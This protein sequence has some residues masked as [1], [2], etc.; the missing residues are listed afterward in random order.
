MGAKHPDTFPRGALLGA[1]VLVGLALA[2]TGAARLTGIGIA[3]T[4]EATSTAT[5]DLRFEDR[6]D[7]AVI[8]YDAANGR[9]VDILEPGTNGFVRGV[10]RAL[11]RERK[12]QDIGPA[13][14]F[15]L[16]RWGDGRLSIEDVATQERIELV[17]FGPTNAA[18]FARLL[19][20]RSA[21][22]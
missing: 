19:Y 17:S 21:S 8:V 11:V 10:L 18:A 12:R 3:R 13:S 6:A 4:P 1:A 9:I 22:K 5:R 20:D 15:R 14:P 7:G 16:T 2:F